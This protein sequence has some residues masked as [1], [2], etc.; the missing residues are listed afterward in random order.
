MRKETAMDKFRIM[1]KAPHSSRVPGKSLPGKFCRALSRFL[2]GAVIS[3]LISITVVACIDEL[4][5]LYPVL[6]ARPDDGTGSSP[7]SA[8]TIN[9]T[10]HCGERAVL[11]TWTNPGDPDFDL[12]EITV[13]SEGVKKDMFR[14]KKSDAGI[15]PGRKVIGGLVNGTAY[16]FT[17]EIMTQQ[18]KSIG[19]SIGP[20]TPASVSDILRKTAGG[21]DKDNPIRLPIQIDLSN[22]SNNWEL[23]LNNIEEGGKY[24][25]LDLSVC[26]FT[27]NAF[28]PGTSSSNGKEYIVSIVLPDAAKSIRGRSMNGSAFLRFTNLKSVS[29]KNVE[30]VGYRA[31]SSRNVL[32]TAD[33][34]KAT[35]IDDQAFDGCSALKT[36]SLP[37][38]EIIGNGVF[39]NSGGTALTITLGSVPPT[40]GT[41]MFDRVN[42][43]KSITVKVPVGA[44]GKY[45]KNWQTD[46]KGGNTNIALTIEKQ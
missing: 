3:V 44:T 22:D 37:V 10:G 32:E 26:P 24:V 23:L 8:E 17:V 38:T 29:G 42:V 34:P 4:S 18:G 46:F 21:S 31:F 7:A 15:L 9:L 39:S 13:V 16:T 36:I 2:G 25:E 20:L 12:I 28:D 41:D 27:N 19:Q 35:K 5:Q 40:L 11:L 45:D 1:G 30:T 14:I 6:S 43:P 33:F